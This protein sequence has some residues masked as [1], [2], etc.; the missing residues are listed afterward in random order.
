MDYIKRNYP[1][2]FR[3]ESESG[4]IYGEE[5]RTY[6]VYKHTCPN[7]K[8]YIGITG[9]NII[10]RWN[11]GWGYQSQTYFFR[12]IQK[13]GW[14][15][16]KH[17]IL[18][19]GLTKEEA[20][21]KEIELITRY[22]SNQREYGYNVETGGNLGKKLNEE[23]KKKISDSRKGRRWDFFKGHKHTAETKELQRKRKIELFKTEKHPRA[24]PVLQIDENGEV[25]REWQSLRQACKGIGVC[26]ATLCEHISTKTL[27]KS[28][29]WCYKGV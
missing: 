8:V 18:F 26:P 25:V 24:K 20:E 21:Q 23:T 6:C 7:G 19:D 12:A 3:A 4:L 28:F 22:K 29:S 16:I 11:R 9:M 27:C 15:N 1:A 2:E 14:Q 10:R 5:Q 17:E 13:Y